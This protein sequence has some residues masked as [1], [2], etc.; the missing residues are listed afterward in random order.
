[1]C[2]KRNKFCYV[3][4]FF[5]DI[6]HQIR[7]DTNKSVILAYNELF[8]L[9]YTISKSYEPEFVCSVCAMILKGWKSRKGRTHFQFSVPMMWKPVTKHNRRLC[10]LCQTD[11]TGHHFKTR[12][13]IKYADVSTITKPI[14]IDNA[15]LPTIK[16][17]IINENTDVN[18]AFNKL[19]ISTSSESTDASQ[20]DQDMSFETPSTSQKPQFISNKKY[21]DLVRDLTLTWRQTELLASRLKEFKLVAPDFK[22]TF[23]RDHDYR[24]V[25]EKVFKKDNAYEDLVHCSNI[26]ELFTAFGCDHIPKHW[27]LFIDDSNKS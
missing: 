24:K 14:L 6:K 8:K 11:I 4:G 3:C 2:D 26:T 12:K 15:E 27:R 16:E 13:F 5:V 10:Y 9:Y 25:F 22:I 1:M 7:F 17:P 18:I 20:S 23:A 21:L 19:R